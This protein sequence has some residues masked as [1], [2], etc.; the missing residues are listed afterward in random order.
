MLCISFAPTLK[1]QPIGSAHN[2]QSFPI[3]FE[4]R[5]FDSKMRVTIP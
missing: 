1:N 4:V 3:V 2:A 5:R